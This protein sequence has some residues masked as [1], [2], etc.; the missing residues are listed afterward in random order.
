MPTALPFSTSKAAARYSLS[1][2]S[3]I[4]G[5]CSTLDD[6]ASAAIR[7][8][9]FSIIRRNAFGPRPR[10]RLSSEPPELE[11]LKSL[12]ITNHVIMRSFRPLA[13]I[14]ESRSLN[15]QAQW[16]ASCAERGASQNRPRPQFSGQDLFSIRNG[17][18]PRH[19]DQVARP[20][21]GSRQRSGPLY[22][23]RG[24][25]DRRGDGRL[26]SVRNS[27]IEVGEIGWQ[28]NGISSCP[29]CRSSSRF[30]SD[31]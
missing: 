1:N 10:N 23:R 12:A 11:K 27:P 8:S 6:A 30:T 4:D 14:F 15:S 24:L 22:R 9:A 13:E 5:T 16:S 21:A 25:P 17:R 29:A 28:T 7:A 2:R 18:V 31:G 20:L 19:C 3:S 26:H